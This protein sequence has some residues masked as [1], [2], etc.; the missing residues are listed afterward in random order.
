VDLGVPGSIPGGG[1]YEI[2]SLGG[3]RVN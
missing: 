3:S 2:S 1:T